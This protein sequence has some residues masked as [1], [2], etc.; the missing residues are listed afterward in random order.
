MESLYFS[1]Y[2]V[3]VARLYIHTLKSIQ[4]VYEVIPAAYKVTKENHLCWRCQ[5]GNIVDSRFFV[6]GEIADCRHEAEWFLQAKY[7]TL[8]LKY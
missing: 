3:S 1:N 2:Q 4:A 8:M 7:Q 6:K 5:I